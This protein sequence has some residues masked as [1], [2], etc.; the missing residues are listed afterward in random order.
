MDFATEVPE[1]VGINYKSTRHAKC[2][3]L[4]KMKAALRKWTRVL[5][6]SLREGK[7]LEPLVKF[8]EVV[9]CVSIILLT[10]LICNFLFIVIIVWLKSFK[11]V[12]ILCLKL[13]LV[14]EVKFCMRTAE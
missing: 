12:K 11:D 3:G 6:G 13:W 2:L 10:I 1:D 7:K 4:Q 14:K 5:N 8:F 9:L